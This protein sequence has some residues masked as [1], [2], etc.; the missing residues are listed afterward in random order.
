MPSPVDE[1]YRTA[2]VRVTI[3][4]VVGFAVGFALVARSA[5]A[6][7]T[8]GLEA[9]PAGSADDSPVRW[10]VIGLAD[11]QPARNRAENS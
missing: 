7:E 6:T 4:L 9:A 3:A 8:A 10:L 2:L 1:Q 5:G 11:G